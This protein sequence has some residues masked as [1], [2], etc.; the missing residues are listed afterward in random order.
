MS[1]ETQREMPESVSITLKQSSRIN[2]RVA[3]AVLGNK[4]NRAALFDCDCGHDTTYGG[5]SY[6]Y[7]TKDT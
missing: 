3:M 2:N 1:R 7:N 6:A 4:S 5:V